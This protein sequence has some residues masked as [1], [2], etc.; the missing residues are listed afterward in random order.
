MIEP[1]IYGN[2]VE[3]VLAVVR[4]ADSDV[5]TLV[6]VGHNPSIEGVAVTLDDGSGPAS[7]EEIRGGFPTSG[8]AVLSI[9]GEWADLGPERATLE[10]FAA[11]RG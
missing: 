10:R 7:R 5:A 2:T 9:P 1:R 11:P 3:D 6:I 4:A 8:V